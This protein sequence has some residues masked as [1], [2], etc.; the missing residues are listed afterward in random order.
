MGLG[1]CGEEVL[2]EEDKGA[3]AEERV[4]CFQ[5]D[6]EAVGARE[7][8]GDPKAGLRVGAELGEVLAAVPG[9][10]VARPV[11][12]LGRH[13][14]AGVIH[15]DGDAVVPLLEGHVHGRIRRRV[16]HRVVQQER[17]SV[18][19]GSDGP[20]RHRSWQ[21]LGTDP[22]IV[23]DVAHRGAYHVGQGSCRPPSCQLAAGQYGP[24]LGGQQHLLD[25][26]V[27]AS[28]RLERGV[29]LM[30]PYPLAHLPTGLR[31]H[32][33]EGGRHAPHRSPGGLQC[34]RVDLCRLLRC[35]RADLADFFRCCC[36]GLLDL[37]AGRALDVLCDCVHDL[38]GADH[39]RRQLLAD[40][41][42][43]QLRGQGRESARPA[44]VP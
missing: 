23:L 6:A 13:A 15:Q 28:Q 43:G 38:G 30:P 34:G 20:A 22:L 14:Q 11:E 32:P 39:D 36:L 21:F 40:R 25:G 8:G 7:S 37:P 18:H 24:P 2:G 5:V 27:D 42:A 10:D 26:V 17:Q 35:G 3:R 29:A 1:D 9:E 41:G 31:C 19:D 33:D 16:P 4:R 12:L 44:G